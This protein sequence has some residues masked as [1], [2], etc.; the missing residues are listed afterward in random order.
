MKKIFITLLLFCFY[1]SQAW[2][3]ILI[4]S[5]AGSGTEGDL[6]NSDFEDSTDRNQW[7]DTGTPDKDHSSAGLSM[8]GSYV[9]R[10]D[11]SEKITASFS[12]SANVYIIY[13]ARFED[14]LESNE[15]QQAIL[16]SSDNQLC[17]T[18]INTS[19][20]IV[21]NFAGPIDAGFTEDT[22]LFIKMYYEKGTGADA[23]CGSTYW[24]GS[25]W[26]T[27]SEKTDHTFTADAAKIQLRNYQDGT[28]V[29]YWYYDEVHVF[30]TDYTGDPGDL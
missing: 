20:Y 5:T 18:I 11:T 2:G 19:G 27:P 16:D 1:V 13:Q 15:Y 9:A 26:A 3:V 29:E 17:Q 6:F 7:T 25:S 4:Q 30:S 24:N 12:A 8:T 14:A 10:V 23:V 22:T 28:G 21:S